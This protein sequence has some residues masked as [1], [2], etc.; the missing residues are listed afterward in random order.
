MKVKGTAVKSINEYVKK[1][2]GDQYQQW[3]DQ[4]PEE[5]KKNNE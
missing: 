5:S 1:G 3:L 2:Y 4:L